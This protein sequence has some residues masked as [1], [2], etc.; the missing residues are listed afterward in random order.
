VAVGG[1]GFAIVTIEKPAVTR[2]DRQQRL[3]AIGLVLGV[4]MVAFEITAVL[5]ALP[6]ITDQLHG[7]SLYG[8]A[9]ASYT[10]AN[11]VALVVT[12]ELTDRFGPAKPYLASLAVFAGGLVVAAT[13][14][15]MALVVIGR[16]LQGAG[17]GGLAPIAYVL[18]K[19]AFPAERQ[20]SLYV[21]LSAGW[22]IPS[23]I[24]PGV[25]GTLT[26]RLGWRWVFWLLLP[27]IPV[28][29]VITVR[30]MRAYGPTASASPRRSRIGAAVLA[31]AG[32]GT[33]VTALQF[34]HP[35]AAVGGAVA[36]LAFGVPSLRRLLPSGVHRAARGLPAAVLCRML[37]TAAFLGADSFIPLAADR[38]H[39]SSPTEQGL[40][41]MGA[42]LSWTGGQWF[43]SRHPQLDPRRAVRLGFGTMAVG[44]GASVPVLASGWSL[45]ATFFLFSIAGFGMGLLF[46]PTTVTAMSHAQEG[47]EGLVSS[48]VYL[49]DAVGFSTMGGIGGAM[50]ALSER[51]SLPLSGA[52]GITFALSIALAGIG[53]FCAGR[54]G[55]A[56]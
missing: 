20:P 1:A 52:L 9:L 13:A 50:V 31:A 26:D 17:T 16:T 8:V 19:R 35:A 33:F 38:I 51:T 2:L 45:W 53:M 29:C 49:A 18:V 10:L 37:A 15:S 48:Q 23:L 47:A 7:D 12:G 41:I 3:L 39:G 30:P 27:L 14:R 5:T 43:V 24:A 40:V 42:S 36:G 4:T 25:A 54:I 46:N 55:A 44:I 21:Y 34:N 11:L 32:L 56:D 28:V 6:S 22:V